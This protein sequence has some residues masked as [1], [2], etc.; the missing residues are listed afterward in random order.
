MESDWISVKEAAEIAG[1][2]IEHVRRLIRTGEVKAR[3]IITVWQVNRRSFMAYL[4]RT[5]ELGE[6][7]GRKSG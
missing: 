6:R 7:R 1:Y 3:K 4:K 5:A 2:H